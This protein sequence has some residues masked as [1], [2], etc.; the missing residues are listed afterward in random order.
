MP[1]PEIRDLSGMAEFR[2]AEALQNAVWGKEDTADP[3]DLMMVIQAEG[4]LCAGAFLDGR[5]IGYV[6][7][8]PTRDAGV[9]HSHRLAVHPGARGLHLGSRLKWYQRDWCLA[10]GIEHVRWTF[11]P[12]RGVNAS[13]NIGA[14]GAIVRTYYTDFYGR[15]APEKRPC[16]RAGRWNNGTKPWPGGAAS[17]TGR[18]LRRDD[19]E[20]SPARACRTAAPARGDHRSDCGRS[21]HHRL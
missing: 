8:F 3:A 15:L 19:P 1:Q 5:L 21:R 6:F 20:R 7:G 14:L 13:L 2:Q 16:Q 18:R 11:D 9:Q 10:R 4:G 17:E 12:L